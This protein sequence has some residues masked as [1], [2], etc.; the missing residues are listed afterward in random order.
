MI[1][2]PFRKGGRG[3]QKCCMESCKSYH[4]TQPNEKKEGGFVLFCLHA[5]M[6]LLHA[7]SHSRSM[8]DVV[9]LRV[10]DRGGEEEEEEEENV[11]KT[12][13]WILRCAKTLCLSLLS[14]DSIELYPN[15]SFRKL[16]KLA[17]VSDY[18]Y[19]VSLWFFQG[20][21]ITPSRQNLWAEQS[22]RYG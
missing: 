8:I 3:R 13:I 12:L 15:C 16:R 19:P 10:W 18:P 14:F 21:S 17:R 2:P 4:I 20:L 7:W 1:I 5:C 22:T 11:E 9:I 6:V